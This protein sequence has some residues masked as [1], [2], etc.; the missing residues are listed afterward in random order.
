MGVIQ[1]VKLDLHEVYSLIG[2]LLL[3]L[4]LISL[5]LFI[6]ISRR[7]HLKFLNKSYRF[8]YNNSKKVKTFFL[9]LFIIFLLGFLSF[10]YAIYDLDKSTTVEVDEKIVIIEIDDYWNIE[11]TSD[12]FERYGYT[13]ER[14]RSISNLLDK[15][16]FV[17][18]L[19]VTPYIFVE[20][21]RKNFALEEDGI[22]VDYLEELDSKGYE[23][24]MHGYNHCRNVN[25]CPQYE[26]VWFN[27][28][29]GKTELERIF[30]R[31][32]MTYFP[33]G[34]YWTTEQYENVKKAGFNLIGNTHVP[35]AYFDEN[36]II[37]NKAYDPIYFYG[38][39]ALDFRHTPVEEWI[40]NYENKNLF[41][42]QLHSNTFDSQEK[43]DDLDE[44]LKYVK[45]DGAK[46]M[47]YG[48]FYNYIQT[49]KQ[50]KG[51]TGNFIIDF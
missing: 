49:K 45:N 19:G 6:L 17:A 31:P 29:N 2:N 24:A 46:V 5:I 28:L 33:P 26:E 8:F 7:L 12:Y 47:T 41:I 3:V 20:E 27:V 39:Y 22:M 40:Q 14:Y 15:H 4:F 25:Y 34:N 35:K 44:F 18:S 38:W 9:I 23:L 30:S 16:D 10:H 21:E 42:L 48:D 37:T 50:E 43:L 1:F 11:D 51:L 36:V 13:M 32:F